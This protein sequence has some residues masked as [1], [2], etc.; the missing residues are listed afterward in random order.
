MLFIK[1][2][3]ESID[4]SKN[5]NKVVKDISKYSVSKIKSFI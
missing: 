5:F 2:E 4:K 3:K 1:L